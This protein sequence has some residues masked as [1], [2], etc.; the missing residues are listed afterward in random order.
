MF[1]ELLDE[2]LGWD[3]LHS[4]SLLLVDNSVDDLQHKPLESV[5]PKP[6]PSPPNTSS[7]PILNRFCEESARVGEQRQAIEGLDRDES[8]YIHVLRLVC[9][10]KRL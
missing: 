4:D 9:L 3:I 2:F 8:A 10:S 6:H 5:S 7:A 1:G